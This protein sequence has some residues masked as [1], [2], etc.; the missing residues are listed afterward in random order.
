M[1]KTFSPAEVAAHTTPETGMYLIVDDGVYDVAGES[2]YEAA[3]QSIPASRLSNS[4]SSDIPLQASSKNTL[5]V[6]R[7]SSDKSERMPRNRSGRLVP[8]VCQQLV[9][10]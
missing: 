3:S 8:C 7:F 2:N 9:A 1:S 4:N 10:C 6:R 5:A